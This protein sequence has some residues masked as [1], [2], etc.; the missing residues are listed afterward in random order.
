[1]SARPWPL[2]LVFQREARTLAIRFDN[3]ESFEIP[4][5]LLRVDSPSAE[6]RGHGPQA[7]VIGGKRNVGVTRAE[8]V[9]RY[10]VR[11]VFDDG[12]DSGLF[13]W[14]YLREL[15]R[16]KHARMS[17]YAESQCP[18]GRRAGVDAPELAG[19]RSLI[20]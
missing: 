14:D 17:A 15:G 10:A 3:G 8:P 13:S 7:R 2:E 16:E 1:M 4:F 9:G 19:A 11:I 12:H 5:E 18:G 20:H 6:E